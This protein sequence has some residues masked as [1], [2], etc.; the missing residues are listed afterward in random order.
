MPVIADNLPRNAL[1]LVVQICLI[2]ELLCSYPLQL[3][4]VTSM[5]EEAFLNPENK[6]YEVRTKLNMISFVRSFVR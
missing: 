1:V 6:H 5:V 4:P 2:V 3:A